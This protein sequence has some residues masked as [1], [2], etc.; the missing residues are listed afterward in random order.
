[1]L[2]QII[3]LILLLPLIFA[4][5]VE[6]CENKTIPDKGNECN[7]VLSISTEKSVYNNKEKIEIYNYD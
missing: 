3:I 2:K 7:A 5:T 6:I 1:M 4:K